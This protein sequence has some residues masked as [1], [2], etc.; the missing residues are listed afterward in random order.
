MTTI[1]RL[2]WRFHRLLIEEAAQGDDVTHRVRSR[3]SHLP[4]EIIPQARELR[5]QGP[6]EARLIL[7]EPSAPCFWP[8][9]RG[10]LGG[11]AQGPKAVCAVV[12][13]C[14]R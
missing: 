4:V 8:T 11:P 6:P 1:P 7:P 9:R 13:R 2:P 12:I 5:G 10:R 3:L 14:C